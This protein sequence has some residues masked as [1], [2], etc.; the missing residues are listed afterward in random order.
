MTDDE[1][2]DMLIA[3]LGPRHDLHLFL[4]VIRRDIE[5]RDLA[6]GLRQCVQPGTLLTP[7]G[8]ALCL[9]RPPV[10]NRRVPGTPRIPQRREQPPPP[11]R[12][13][14][15]AERLRTWAVRNREI[16]TLLVGEADVDKLMHRVAARDPCEV[17]AALCGGHRHGRWR[18]W[19]QKLKR[20]VGASAPASNRES[21]VW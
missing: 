5:F 6:L 10:W 12:P 14:S 18:R 13:P 16:L 9:P 1:I 3:A 2:M 21:K 19:Q 15:R 7:T 4:A 20:L 8:L 11:P 17:F